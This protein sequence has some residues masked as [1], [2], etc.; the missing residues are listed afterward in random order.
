MGIVIRQSI[1]SSI[2]SYIGIII[3]YIN[4]LYL[5]PQ[6][7]GL[8]QIG[9]LRA[10][11]DTAILMAPFAQWGLS[12]TMIR[13]HP[14][15]NQT[16]GQAHRFV[17]LMILLAVT[18]YGLFLLIFFLLEHQI[19]GFFQENAAVVGEYISL[20]LWLTF[21][22]MLTSIMEA[23]TRVLLKPVFAN[24]LR[25]IGVRLLQALSVSLY[26]LKVVNF[27]Q[28]LMLSVGAN[29]VT[30]LVLVIYLAVNGHIAFTISFRFLSS[31][32]FRE[33]AVYS[34]ISFLGAGALLMVG[35]LDSVMVTGIVGLPAN[36]IYT[37]CFYMA[38]VIEIPKRAMAQTNVGLI[39]RAFEKNQLGEIT[40][41]Y[42]K[43]AIN[44][45]IVGTLLLMGIVANLHNLFA[46][47]PKGDVFETGRYVV[48]LVGMAKLSD[49][50]FG[51]N[52][53]ILNLSR[54]YKLNTLALII[55]T[56]SAVVANYILIPRYGINGAAMG[57]IAAMLLFNMTK[58][59]FVYQKL[60]IHPFSFPFIK[61]IV[62]IAITLGIEH[63]LP[64][65]KP[66]VA[67]IAYRSVIITVVYGGLVLVTN[68]SE[69]I[70]KLVQVVLARIGLRR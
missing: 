51:P 20:I 48:L 65:I 54:Y 37:T 38:T 68:S 60:G 58:G 12:Q 29:L 14:Q 30:L 40:S 27:Q 42:K 35:K 41:L 63:L 49:M 67:D 44:L 36:A 3:G 4:L 26:F 39:A 31:R 69:E 28:F 18:G 61:V 9:L 53:E 16:P 8:E 5:Y 70:T 6:F 33:M 15:F 52:G 21:I 64:V 34:L 43:T 59:V 1:Y 22:Y 19:L 13:Y 11:Q 56:V 24:F 55:L 2:I 25:E 7:L 45:F 62:I 32:K 17:N 50:M 46:M 66:V 10:I 47:M 57:T 23:Y